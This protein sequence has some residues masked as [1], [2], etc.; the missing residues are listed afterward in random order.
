MFQGRALFEIRLRT[1]ELAPRYFL[2]VEEKAHLVAPE[3]DEPEGL[4]PWRR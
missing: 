4:C 3:R 2:N 1:I